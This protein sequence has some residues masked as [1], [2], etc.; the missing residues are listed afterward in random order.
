MTS[1]RFDFFTGV[2]EGE[3]EY[4]K[5]G[6]VIQSIH[7]NSL[8]NMRYLVPFEVPEGLDEKELKLFLKK[9]KDA[10]VLNVGVVRKAWKVTGR[11][12]KYPWKRFT[13]V[14]REFLKLLAVEVVSGRLN[15]RW[16]GVG[17]FM[18]VK[19]RPFKQNLTPIYSIFWDKSQRDTMIDSSYSYRVPKS[20]INEFGTKGLNDLRSANRDPYKKTTFAPFSKDTTNYTKR[21]NKIGGINKKLVRRGE[22]PIRQFYG[23]EEQKQALKD[24]LEVLKKLSDYHEQRLPEYAKRIREQK[25]EIAKDKKLYK[26]I[27]EMLAKLPEVV[28]REILTFKRD[29][30][31]N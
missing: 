15:Y 21:K 18:L 9:R 10:A 24:R 6:E 25:E 30:K 12:G 27:N 19:K 23:S 5:F 28:R 1:N 4:D 2:I 11:G 20:S 22:E 14:I 7:D 13:V 29:K 17:E 8:G 16:N 31:E 3:L 26:E